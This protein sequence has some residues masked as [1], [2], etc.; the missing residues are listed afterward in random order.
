M[1]F[2]VLVITYNASWEKLR[3]TLLS[4][5]KQDFDNYEIVI[6]DDGSAHFPED[7]V[8]DFMESKGFSD[9]T[10]VQNTTNQ[11]TV[12]NLLSGL[13]VCRGEYVKFISAGDL[14]YSEKTIEM[15][16]NFMSKNG[17]LC[18]F[19]LMQAY[20]YVDGKLQKEEFNHPFDIEAYRK[21]DYD[22][23][24]KNL[25]LYSD[26]ACGAAI[27]YEREFA[28]EYMKKLENRVRYMEDIFQ[29]LAAVEEKHMDFLDDYVI[30]YELGEG[31]STR[32][33]SSFEGKMRED[34]DNFY[35]MLYQMYPDN[36]YVRK[37]YGLMG[38][39]K[40]KNLYIRSICRLFVNP[41]AIRY[42]MNAR[43]QRKSG[44]H[45]TVGSQIGFLDRGDFE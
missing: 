13:E 5:L 33:K 32:K 34:V 30:W 12:K 3:L 24:T 26:N 25:V 38:I 2:T 43:K 17:S 21:K 22:R 45:K 29:P 35:R 19:G 14:F 28:I 11:G 20:R 6:A 10:L 9:Y 42:L 1:K 40:I 31:V 27:T 36:L 8:R 23:I 4:A 37:R 44:A 7:Q 41:D 39:Y 16:Y 18:S 15:I